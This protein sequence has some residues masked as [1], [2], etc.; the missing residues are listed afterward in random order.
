[1]HRGMTRETAT[2]DSTVIKGSNSRHKPNAHHMPSCRDAAFS[3]LKRNAW[4]L[5]GGVV[6]SRVTTEKH[7]WEISGKRNGHDIRL[8]SG[9]TCKNQTMR[10]QQM[11]HEQLQGNDPCQPVPLSRYQA[12]TAAPNSLCS[13]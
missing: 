9:R 7:W 1:M 12:E 3:G 2:R 13:P 10:P 5:R 6:M 11:A 4:R 8:V